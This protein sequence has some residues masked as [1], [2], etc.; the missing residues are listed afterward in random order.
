MTYK[1]DEEVAQGEPREEQAD[2]LCDYQYP[3]QP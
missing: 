2:E 1:G 3:L